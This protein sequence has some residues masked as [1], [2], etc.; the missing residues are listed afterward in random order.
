MK[1]YLVKILLKFID[2]N[3][4]QKFLPSA[5]GV[6]FNPFY[7]LRKR[8]YKIIYTNKKFISG[9]VL[10]YGCGTSPYK[11]VFNFDEYK[12]ADI[13]IDNLGDNVTKI[14]NAKTIFEDNYFD[15]IICTEVLEH[16]EDTNLA[17]EEMY[18]VLKP[19]GVAIITT[20]F[21]W[22]IHGHPYDFRRFTLAGLTKIFEE[23]K[24]EIIQKHKGANY[25]ESLFQLF[26]TK[27]FLKIQ[28]KNYWVN[29][30]LSVIISPMSVLGLLFGLLTKDKSIYLSNVVIVRKSK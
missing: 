6:F 30:F 24:F 26:I 23:N 10:D 18:R 11:E 14:I 29:V 3:N 8:L 25:F 17:I 5:W 12:R 28:S 15:S 7:I 13:I 27:I 20:P 1:K 4:R 21:V 19:N 22:Q 9:K 2:F 16:V